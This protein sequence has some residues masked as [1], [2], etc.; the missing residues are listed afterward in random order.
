MP[1]C[2]DTDALRDGNRDPYRPIYHSRHLNIYLAKDTVETIFIK[3][4]SLQFYEKKI[5][6]EEKR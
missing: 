2:N 6:T 4:T 1:L 5:Q 3:Q